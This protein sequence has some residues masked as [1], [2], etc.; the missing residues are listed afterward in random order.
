MNYIVWLTIFVWLPTVLLWLTHLKTLK[1]YLRTF[2]FCVFWAL[3]FSI[4]WDLW[5]TKTNIWS[6]PAGHNLGI[7]IG[8]LP[9]EEYFFIVFV[10]FLVSTLTIVLKEKFKK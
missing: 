5:A 1:K 3:V 10:T 7:W 8:G 2:S 4:P 6:F 9:L